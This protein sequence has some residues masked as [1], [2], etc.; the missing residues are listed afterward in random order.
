MPRGEFSSP[1]RASLCSSNPRLPGYPNPNPQRK[2]ARCG[3]ARPR[4]RIG[5]GLALVRRMPELILILAPRIELSRRAKTD[6]F[7]VRNTTFIPARGALVVRLAA[8][9]NRDNGHEVGFVAKN[10]CG[11]TGKNGVE[12][13]RRKY[14]RDAPYRVQHLPSWTAS[15]SLT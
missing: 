4:L 15:P 1:G 10:C 11:G 13:T 6:C 14:C 9:S 3:R 8:R 5:L 2:G 7:V 12:R